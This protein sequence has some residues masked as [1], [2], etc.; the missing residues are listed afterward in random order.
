MKV[1]CPLLFQS[2]FFVPSD[3][4]QPVLFQHLTSSRQEPRTSH[5]S[6]SPFKK[7]KPGAGT[8]SLCSSF[9]LQAYPG[10]N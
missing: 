8:G 1:T 3:N 2:V 6:K 5:Q 7:S 9:K 4:D 10:D